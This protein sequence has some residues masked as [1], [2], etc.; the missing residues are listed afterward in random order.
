MSLCKLLTLS[1]LGGSYG[2]YA[3]LVAAF[4]SADRYQCAVAFAPVTDIN[5]LIRDQRNFVLSKSSINR[6]KDRDNQAEVSPIEQAEHFAIP[7][8]IVHGDVDRTV[9]IEQSRTLTEALEAA[10]ADYRYIEQQNGD[11]FLSLESHRREFLL[12]VDNFLQRHIGIAAQSAD[13]L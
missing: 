3:A 9:R 7:L 10:G 13:G 2:G 5:E 6:L 1:W 8:L 12:A 11:H 4:Q